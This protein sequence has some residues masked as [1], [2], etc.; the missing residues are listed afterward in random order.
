MKKDG[1][2]SVHLGV[3]AALGEYFVSTSEKGGYTENHADVPV[4]FS[5]KGID[6]AVQ[7]INNAL[8]VVCS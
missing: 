5:D 7:M 3:T 6:L 2:S 4:I 8:I 1:S